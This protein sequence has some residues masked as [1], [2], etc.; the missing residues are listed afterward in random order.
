MYISSKQKMKRAGVIR[1][2]I[3]LIPCLFF[4]ISVTAQEITRRHVDSLLLQK[5][6]SNSDAGQLSA[7]L[8][9][10]EFFTHLRHPEA[11]QIDSAAYFIKQ[12]EKINQLFP[13]P[14]IANHI[15]L[16]RSAFYKSRG[17]QKKGKE[18]IV[19]AIKNIRAS[20]DRQLLGKAYFELSEYYSQDFLQQSM[21]SR[22]FYLKLAINAFEGTNNPVELARCYRLLADLHQM[23][24]E[25]T[26]SFAEAKKALAYYHQARY[27][28]TQGLYALLGRLY[29]TH[30]DYKKAIDYELMAMKIATESSADNVRL[31]CQIN[32]NLG[33]DFVKLGDSKK[34]LTYF[35]RALE[36]A[37]TEKDNATIYLLA[38]NIV[39][40]YLRLQQPQKAKAFL[41]QI[42]QKFAYPSVR[43]Y[44]GGDEVSQTYL[45][46]YLALKQYDT[47][48]LYCDR[49]IAQTKNPNLNLYARSGYYELIIK[50]NIATGR[51]SD[52]LKYLKMNQDLLEKI[53]NE[54]D[55]GNN[56]VLWF[57]LDTA[58]RN[59]QSAIHHLTAANSI[60]DSVFNFTKSKQIEQLQIEFETQQKEA[61]ILL[62]NQKSRLEQANLQQANLVK[63]LT[64]GGI[65][66]LL[67]IA[68]LLYRQNMQKQKNNEII[69][70]KNT[71]LQDLLGQ[72]EWL[73]KEVHHRVKNNLQIIMSILNTQSAYLQD[74]TAIEAI[75][76]SQH[77]VNAIALLHQKLYSGTNIA[78][79]SMPSYITE[80]INY[81]SD[82]F[83]ISFRHIRIRQQLDSLN[84]DPAQAVPI[85]L[86]LNEAITNAIKY[87]FN[88]EGGDITV[89][90]SMLNSDDAVLKVCDTGK[91]LPP[92]FD[93][94]KASSLG[95]E[96]M[97]ALGKQLKGE[98][99]VENTSGVTLIITFPVEQSRVE[100]FEGKDYIQ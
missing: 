27:T 2:C 93:F 11:S 22:I 14:A 43:L 89:S 54:N 85:G 38:G 23:M 8:E 17:E 63:N 76:G 39:D 86:I 25:Y 32:N 53:G 82:S 51:F 10:A 5:N 68:V 42:T 70:S 7:L 52:A 100:V 19:E 59:Y 96:M 73:L 33:Y 20:Q 50:F 84:L 87:A 41:T 46:I 28:E 91:G 65:F 79:V 37:K 36:I 69:T 71:L 67:V 99:T 16:L 90:L 88:R 66:L 62:L 57:A 13:K 34:A 60:K 81:L 56:D 78:L 40:V 30:G 15:A 49:L 26:L 74:D 55:M 29:Y 75:R 77:R 98:F 95:M 44:E 31:L 45:K 1:K 24:N 6:F 47:A 83:D 72:K 35:S 21:T 9:L 58:Q 18:L 48:K 97:K 61:Q 12:S 3:L 80:L 64:I 4:I 94:K 92:D